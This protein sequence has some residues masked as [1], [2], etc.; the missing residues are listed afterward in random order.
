MV[1][2]TQKQEFGSAATTDSCCH[3]EE[4]VSVGLGKPNRMLVNHREFGKKPMK[5]LL[6]GR[7][8]VVRANSQQTQHTRI[9]F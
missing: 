8:E 5:L 7:F 2:Q 3:V 6:V 9:L 1:T 4:R